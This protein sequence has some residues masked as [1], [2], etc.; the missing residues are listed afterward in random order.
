[1]ST[2]LR[3]LVP[4]PV[5]VRRGE[6]RPCRFAGPVEIVA[7]PDLGREAR[8]LRRTLEE[9]TGWRADV[10]CPARSEVPAKEGATTM[11]V[12]EIAPDLR[13]ASRRSAGGAYRLV[14]GDGRVTISGD[15][16]AGVFYGLQ[17]LRQLLPD[18][19][20]RRAPVLAGA[21][22]RGR[23]GSAAP[24]VVEPVVVEDH[25]RLSWRGVHLDV[26]RHFMPKSFLLRLVDLLAFHK[27]NVFHL[28]LTDDQGW[29]LPVD[30]YP[31]LVE[32][33]AWR[34]Q[35]PAGHKRD[36]LFDGVPH[37]GYYTKED[38]REVVAFAAERHVTV[39]PEVEMPGHVVA[40]L[41]AYPKLG[42]RARRL[43][44]GTRWGVYS[45]VLNLEDETLRFCADVVDELCQLFPGPFV[46]IGGDECPTTEWAR[47]P[48]ARALMERERLTSVRQLQ[49]WFG[50]RVAAEVAGH[51]RRVVGWEEILEGGAPSD[52]V[53]MAWRGVKGG[54]E[55]ALAGHDVVMAPEEWLYFDWAHSD[56]VA[57][58]LAIRGATP[59]EKVYAFDPVLDE[60]PEDQ[61][62]HVLGA[63]CQL[64]T[65]YVTTPQR[66]EYQYF[67]RLCAF[68]ETVWSPAAGSGR[69][70]DFGAFEPRLARHLDRLAAMD[71][72]YRPLGGPTPGQARMW[73]AGARA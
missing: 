39:V 47:S 21:P 14:A 60:L 4:A 41:A 61:R 73:R 58:P 54:V 1:M 63:Q 72:Q 66:A 55:A 44:V 19:T 8:W 43:Q 71:V 68:A 59:V 57:E 16:P 64:W 40:A 30:R 36:R 11:V 42:N 7:T 20:L 28:H 31:L 18:S 56:D 62:H 51:G 53:V 34:K 3:G 23:R 15:G 46:H 52:A 35:S 27:C 67:P 32:V 69:R 10:V 12:L 65:E 45:Q 48:R 29:R 50:A 24:A 5:S 26:C 22:T 25:P 17:T 9:G 70:R 38:L 37:G 6:G 13:R 33:G 2:P 49:G